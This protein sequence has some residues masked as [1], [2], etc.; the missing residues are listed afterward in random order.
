VG[1][2]TGAIPFDHR[3]RHAEDQPGYEPRVEIGAQ[4]AVTLRL[5]DDRGDVAVE[6]APP[7]DRVAFAARR[8]VDAK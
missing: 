7:F 2:G 6:R 8:A 3:I 4:V 1:E 5:R